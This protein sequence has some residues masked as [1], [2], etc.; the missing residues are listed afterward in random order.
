[1]RKSLIP[2]IGLAIG[3]AS[4]VVPAHASNVHDDLS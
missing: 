1:M 3:W 2:L 4:L